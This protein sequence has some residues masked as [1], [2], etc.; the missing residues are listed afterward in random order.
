M[1]KLI[2]IE[3]IAKTATQSQEKSI[4]SCP[5]KLE[6]QDLG[7]STLSLILHTISRRSSEADLPSI[8][9]KQIYSHWQNTLELEISNSQMQK[10]IRILM[11]YW[12]ELKI[13][14]QISQSARN[15]KLANLLKH[16]H[17]CIHV[18]NL[19]SNRKA[20]KVLH[21]IMLH[22]ITSLSNDLMQ[23]QAELHSIIA[24]HHHIIE[25]RPNYQKISNRLFVS[26]TQKTPHMHNTLY[27]AMGMIIGFVSASMLQLHLFG[28]C[29]S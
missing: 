23:K 10:S 16:M 24:S 25:Q 5:I 3:C 29:P 21:Y 9:L 1:H 22:P 13:D 6:N 11:N 14:S 28:M 19:A 26:K 4:D 8:K 27:I 17:T 2:P 18:F 7:S 20:I 15:E 12:I